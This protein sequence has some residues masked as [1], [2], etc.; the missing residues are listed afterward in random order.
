KPIRPAPEDLESAA[1]PD[2]RVEWGEQTYG[3][4]LGVDIDGFGSGPIPVV[5]ANPRMGQTLARPGE[6]RFQL[7][8]PLRYGVADSGDQRR[9]A[10]RRQRRID[11]HGDVDQR[12]DPSCALGPVDAQRRW[13][14]S[15]VD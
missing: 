8:F 15:A 11:V 7:L 6:G 2:H 14:A 12:V 3:I 9:E 5:V 13:F 4:R 10:A 1:I